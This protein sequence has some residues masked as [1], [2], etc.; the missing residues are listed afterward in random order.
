MEQLRQRC[1]AHCERA[2]GP[3]LVTTRLR[4]PHIGGALH[5]TTHISNPPSV[6]HNSFLQQLLLLRSGRWPAARVRACIMPRRPLMC[7]LVL[8]LVLRQPAA[9]PRSMQGPHCCYAFAVAAIATAADADGQSARN[10]RSEL[11]GKAVVLDCAQS[12]LR[13][14][15]R[16][17][18]GVCEQLGLCVC[19]RGPWR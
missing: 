8:V 17:V 7:M 18:S 14:V 12:C 15:A 11:V 19:V 2:T 3:C 4:P 6:V 16:V 10:I 13:A 9:N 5:P 1:Q